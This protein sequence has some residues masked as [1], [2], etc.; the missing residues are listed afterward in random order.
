MRTDASADPGWHG[1]CCD[2]ARRKAG[3]FNNELKEGGEYESAY[4]EMQCSPR[5]YKASGHPVYKLVLQRYGKSRWM[6]K[7]QRHREERLAKA[8]MF[9]SQTSCVVH[10]RSARP[11]PV[12]RSFCSN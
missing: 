8:E 1:S 3:W 12:Q 4:S 2:L 10:E 7:K 6:K 5:R 11:S 9:A